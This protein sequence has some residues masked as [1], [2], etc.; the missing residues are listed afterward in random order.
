MR[1]LIAIIIFLIVIIGGGTLW[2]HNQVL[3]VD[4]TNKTPT[5]FVINKGDGVREI[6]A[7]LKERKLIKSPIA[8]FLLVKKLGVD[9][10]IEAGDF[11][12][13]PSMTASE[14]AF[15]LT[16][17]TLDIWIT[18]PEGQ[19]ASEIADTL[20]AQIPNFKS[21]WKNQL[22]LNEGYL[23]PDTYLIPKD[24][25]IDII[26]HIMRNN[27]DKKFN[28]IK[29]TKTTNLTNIETVILASLVEREARFAKDRPIVA[30]VILNRL[31]EG[32]PLQIDATVQYTL[33]YQK[34]EKNWWK[35]HLTIDDL[36]IN[37]SYNTYINVGLTPSPI[38]NPGES[39]LSAAL[40]P[41]ATDYLYYV[42]DKN[43][44]LHFAKTLSEHNANIKKYEVQ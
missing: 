28:N 13:N 7:N 42:S 23:F 16:H 14:I 37:S 38:S 43:G 44:N 40:N 35:R 3:P 33:G 32:M 19:R 18:I 31:N 2:W 25:D 26:I 30:S 17:G 4:A 27:F 22:Y 1:R 24:A 12:L 10:K 5:I 8:F 41:P 34:L 11:R 29:N 21:S 39:A 36:K 20:Q 15:T 6:S 9:K